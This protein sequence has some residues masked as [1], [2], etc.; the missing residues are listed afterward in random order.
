MANKKVITVFVL[1]LLAVLSVK[2]TPPRAWE[3]AQGLLPKKQ[4]SNHTPNLKAIE[5]KNWYT[6]PAS[7]LNRY[8]ATLSQ[9]AHMATSR[10]EIKKSYK[11]L[12]RSTNRINR[13]CD[14]ATLP[15]YKRKN[16]NK[17]ILPYDITRSC[18]NLADFYVNA[19]DVYT[20]LQ[21][22]MV[23]QGPLDRTVDDFWQSVLHN[24]SNVIVTLCMPIEEGKK[25][26]ASY[27]TVQ[28]VDLD[29]WIITQKTKELLAQSAL[30]P[31]HNIV[32]RTFI[33]KKGDVERTI[34]HLHY[35]NWPD[36]KIPELNLFIKLLDIVD[37]YTEEGSPIT[38]HCSAGIGRSG[39][40]V[41]AHSLR[42]E[43]RSIL[44]HKNSKKQLQI[45]IPKAIFL[46]RCQRTGLVASRGQYRIVY[47]TIAR[48]YQPRNGPLFVL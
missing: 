19:N 30:I 14:T 25:K 8:D 18:S 32:L 23:C 6:K 27:W 43:I 45:N 21:T 4:P 47:Q 10:K 16:R 41:A 38:V 33:A 9:I 48:D 20:P 44:A 1:I 36:G 31:S 24:H 26:C 34:Y 35:E 29:G 2:Y 3:V 39:T 37:R 42:K 13:T 40:F 28:E 15:I 12:G 46:L 17:H 7:R 5:Q 22:Y 11:A